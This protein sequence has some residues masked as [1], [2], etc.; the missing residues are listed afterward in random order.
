MQAV[1]QAIGIPMLAN[2]NIQCMD[3]VRRCMAYT[4]ADGVMSADPLL[5][6]PA[7]FR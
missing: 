2:G 7:L 4:G 5:A 6:N 1:R 3:D